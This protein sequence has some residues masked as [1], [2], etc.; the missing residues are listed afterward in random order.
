MNHSNKR[1]LKVITYY[2]DGT[3]SEWSPTDTVPHTPSYPLNPSPWPQWN[4]PIR[5]TKCGIVLENAMCYSCNHGDC[6]VGMGPV[7]CKVDE[8]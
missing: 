5:C 8:S 4:A 2:S 7:M 1:I 6:P 3:S